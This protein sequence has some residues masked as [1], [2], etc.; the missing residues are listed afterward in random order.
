MKAL[1]P[2][3]LLGFSI[4]SLTQPNISGAW[5]AGTEE[6]NLVMIVADKFYSV[7]VYNLKDKSYT[8]TY[9]GTFRIEKGEFVFINE[10]NTLNKDDIGVEGR[11]AV[12]VKG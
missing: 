7:A 2:L 3:I 12:S 9:G 10:F 5:Q 1:L 4:I 8:G 11:S 6:N